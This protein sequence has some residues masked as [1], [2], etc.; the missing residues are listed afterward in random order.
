VPA[1][2][3]FRSDFRL[4]PEVCILAP[5]PNG[6]GHYGAIPPGYQVIAV[7][8]AVMIEEVGRKS[9]WLMCHADQP[10]FGR[11]NAGFKGTRVFGHVALRRARA[12]LDP[13]E[14]V[15]HFT[16]PPGML[17]PE[18]VGRVDGALWCG[19]TVSGCALQLAYN[20]GAR[21]VLLCGVDM[22]GDGYW[23]GT[24]NA[25]DTHGD[26]WPAARRFNGLV[27]WLETERG[28]EVATLS[29]TRL[30]VREYRAGGE[31]R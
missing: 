4:A 12:G 22:S 28:V 5:G 2:D 17:E 25:R 3:V 30:D 16:A 6:R 18:A 15:Y 29:P 24:A 8:K 19:T 26:V 13:A 20:F 31:A 11:A 27:R 7:S 1:I 14:T 23:D 9:V 21:R 10:W